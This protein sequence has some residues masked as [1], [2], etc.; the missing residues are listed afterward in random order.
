MNENFSAMKEMLW[1]R[2]KNMRLE[3]GLKVNT[4][5]F[6]KNE[7]YPVLLTGKDL[8]SKENYYNS[9]K[10]IFGIDEFV[11]LL[12][13]Q[14][15][16]EVK[17]EKAQIKAG[18]HFC[19]L[20]DKIEKEIVEKLRELKQTVAQTV[21]P[22]KLCYEFCSQLSD[23]VFNSDEV[24]LKATKDLL[25]S[26]EEYRKTRVPENFEEINNQIDNRLKIII[27][28]LDQIPGSIRK[29]CLTKADGSQLPARLK[30]EWTKST[31][32][33]GLNSKNSGISPGPT[34][35][36][37]FYTMKQNE[38]HKIDLKNGQ[39]ILS[40]KFDLG[41]PPATTQYG[42]VQNPF[43]SSFAVFSHNKKVIYCAESGDELAIIDIGKHP[44]NIYSLAWVSNVSIAIG[45]EK[46][47][48]FV[49]DIF[50]GTKLMSTSLSSDHIGA[51]ACLPD[52]TIIAGDYAGRLFAVD[53]QTQ[54]KTWDIY[55]H[56]TSQISHIAPSS[57]GE[58]IATGGGKCLK[59]Y[60]V[61]LQ[62][63][64]RQLDLMTEPIGLAW[65]SASTF[66][67]IGMTNSKKFLIYDLEKKENRKYDVKSESGGLANMILIPGS[68]MIITANE[69]GEMA[70]FSMMA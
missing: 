62:Q 39:K 20:L 16:Y 22:N 56:H 2:I 65:N 61:T 49:F 23:G 28:S 63:T 25:R 13:E 53:T 9:Q 44:A 46:G 5:Q 19:F 32:T 38:V 11:D 55:G 68:E 33:S 70:A 6:A 12:I 42:I 26:M 21:L 60:H 4:V 37:V 45:Y 31:F 69:K 27:N 58:L 51:L 29:S 30:K 36:S 7:K 43:D 14:A 10:N 8:K 41:G 47:S 67:V 54:K 3:D 15:D 50:S 34:G 1:S 24:F 57:S 35:S 64:V 48:L 17:K 59:V 40:K 66:I 52:A 18:E